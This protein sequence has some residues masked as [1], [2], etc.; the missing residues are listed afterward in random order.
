LKNHAASERSKDTQPA[1]KDQTGEKEKK[2]KASTNPEQ[3]FVITLIGTEFQSH[4]CVI[5]KKRKRKFKPI[6]Q[7]EEGLERLTGRGSQTPSTDCAKTHNTTQHNTL[8][9]HTPQTSQFLWL[10]LATI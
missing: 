7:I 10:F 2:S 8:N 6:K 4:L 1:R 5:Q 3:L 9:H